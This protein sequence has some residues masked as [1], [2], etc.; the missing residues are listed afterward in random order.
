MSLSS[1]IVIFVL[2]LALKVSFIIFFYL[3]FSAVRL[4]F[5]S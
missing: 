1:R 3:F 5:G 4:Q 2:D